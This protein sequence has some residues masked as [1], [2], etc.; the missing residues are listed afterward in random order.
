MRALKKV[1]KLIETSP[2][3]P[4][5]DIF[6]RLVVALETEESFPLADLYKLDYDD[7]NLALELFAEWRLDR[8]YASKLRL[9]DVSMHI[10]QLR[11][12]PVAAPA[13][14]SAPA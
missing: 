3:K 1:R 8:Y 11:E 13:A 7:F 14:A 10:D 4:K 5:A 12:E 6:S 9:L 2:G